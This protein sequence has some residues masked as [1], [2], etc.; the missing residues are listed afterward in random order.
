MAGY[1]PFAQAP[2]N[3]CVQTTQLLL[4]GELAERVRRAG[5]RSCED[6]PARG[7]AARSSRQALWWKYRHRADRAG[8]TSRPPPSQRTG[9][10][11]ATMDTDRCFSAISA[12]VR[13]RSAVCS[14]RVWWW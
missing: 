12:V 14:V 10:T 6:R 1:L 2:G 13:S 7:R 3:S 5:V 9:Q 4:H 11:P 8:F